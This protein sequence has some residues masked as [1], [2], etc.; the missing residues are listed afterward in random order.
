MF[1]CV[2]LLSRVHV[3]M[4]GKL[5]CAHV[6][7]APLEACVP[8]CAGG[9]DEGTLLP[10]HLVTTVEEDIGGGWGGGYTETLRR[11]AKKKTTSQAFCGGVQQISSR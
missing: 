7:G 5:P 8:E 11:S 10:G 1:A 6:Q 9:C 2:G 3:Q 4:P